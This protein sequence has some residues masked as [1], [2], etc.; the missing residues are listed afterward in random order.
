MKTTFLCLFSLLTL[1]FAPARAA[2]TIPGIPEI[3]DTYVVTVSGPVAAYDVKLVLSAL[4]KIPG[5]VDV[6]APVTGFEIYE[7]TSPSTKV[8][9]RAAVAE[10]LLATP[11]FT[12]KS[13][14][15]KVVPPAVPAPAPAPV[16]PKPVIPKPLVPVVPAKV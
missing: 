8:V 12:V 10:V 1:A 7:L 2:D 3:R 5:V 9:D 13:V 6:A 16:V 11:D 14:V 4:N 15:K